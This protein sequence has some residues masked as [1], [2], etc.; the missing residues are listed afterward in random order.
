MSDINDDN[1]TQHTQ[2]NSGKTITLKL[3]Q[4]IIIVI[5]VAVVSI[6]CTI[7]VNM[8]MQD[9]A[10]HA[11]TAQSYQKPKT[12]TTTK[13]PV[14]KSQRGNLVKH[15][16]DIAAIC[17]DTSCKTEIARWKVTNI[18]LD[19]QCPTQANAIVGISDGKPENGHFIAFDVEVTTT[20][21]YD[22]DSY[23]SLALGTAS[24]WN[25][26][27]KDGTQWNGEMSTTESVNC[28]PR[29]QQLPSVIGG[30]S[31]AKGKIIFD[32]PSKDGY[33]VYANGTTGWE[34]PLN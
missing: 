31:K 11:A 4:F 28:I 6:A 18:T 1:A 17:S 5:V 24:A 33:L 8:V 29:E 27:M 7:T 12:Q 21:E 3:W 25:Y 30:G 10:K 26:F 20:P 23:G 9:N 15:I 16:G 14:K 2:S 32:V 34:Y 22:A 19:Y 13:R